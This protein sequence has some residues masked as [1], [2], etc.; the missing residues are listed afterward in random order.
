MPFSIIEGQFRIMHTQ[1][2]GDPVRFYPTGPDA[3]TQLHLAA[4]RSPRPWPT[5][6]RAGPARRSN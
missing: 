4:T 1:P 5:P 3:F 6:G 2:D